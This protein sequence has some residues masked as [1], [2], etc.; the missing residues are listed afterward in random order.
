MTDV[1][2]GWTPTTLGVLGDYLNGRA[3]KK[4]EWSE[5]GRPIIRIQNLTGSTRVVNRYA[6]HLDERY[7]VRPGDLLVSWA[8]TL[9]A[10]IWAGE[11][12]A[13]NQH[14]FKVESRINLKFHK[15]LLD[16]KLSELMRQ[17]HGSGMVHITRSRFDSVPVMIPDAP[18]QQRIVEILEDHLSRLDAADDYL[19]AASRRLGRL[20]VARWRSTFGSLREA[21]GERPLLEVVSIENGQTPGGLSDALLDHP[22]SDTVPFYKVG[23][24]N[25]AN[26]REMAAARFHVRLGDAKMLGLHVRE[27]G[28]VLIPKRGGAIGTNKKRLLKTPAAFDLNTMGLR[29]S[30]AVLPEYLWHWIEGVDLGQIADGSN[31]PQ[32]NAPQIRRLALP[33]PPLEV[34]A[35]VCA[36]SDAFVDGQATPVEG[37]IDAR[38]RSARLRMALLTAAFSGRLTGHSSDLELAGE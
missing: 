25:S 10:Y 5:H 13:L 9:G 3:F 37:C 27:G 1:P 17:T 7:L 24:M 16:H 34:Q 38:L 22:A 2:P 32:I 35:A 28:L 21:W 26:G 30:P 18:E 29:P 12:G 8:A 14:I 11:E 19:D 31:V 4:T 33:V 6:G 36:G 15:Y 20:R 23:D